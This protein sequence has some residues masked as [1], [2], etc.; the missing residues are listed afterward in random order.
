M[1]NKTA[2]QFLMAIYLRQP[3]NAVRKVRLF[4]EDYHRIFNKEVD[5]HKLFLV[6]LISEAIAAERGSL[7]PDLLASYAAVR[8]TIAYLVGQVLRQ[9][10]LGTQLLNEPQR[11]VPNQ[12]TEVME[13]LRQ[14]AA[15][16]INS[17]NYY[18]EGRLDELGEQFDVKTVFK[19]GAGVRPMEADVIN[20]TRRQARR[21]TTYL[22]NIAP[23]G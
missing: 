3:W 11:W 1:D 22:F 2:A 20:A 10:E 15:D 21:D 6:H 18:V 16:V 4:D 7:R 12:E 13:A 17:M 5:G 23:S 9:S 8:L 19:S 14:I